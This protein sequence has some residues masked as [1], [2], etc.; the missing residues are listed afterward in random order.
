MGG[1][2]SIFHKKSAS[3]AQKTCHFAYF[4]SQWGGSSPPAPRGYATGLNTCIKEILLEIG[5]IEEMRS[6]CGS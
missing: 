5:F 2:F 3:K 6:T 1:L 4:T